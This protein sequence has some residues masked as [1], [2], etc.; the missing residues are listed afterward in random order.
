[1]SREL[2][3]VC[4]RMPPWNG[5][6][7]QRVRV[8][9]PQLAAHGW[10]ATVL[11]LDES[12]DAGSMDP[13]LLATVP[14]EAELQRVRAWPLRTAG[15]LG[16]RQTAL[17]GWWPLRRA[18]R[19][20]LRRRRFDAAL[21]S[22]TDFA[23]WP[24]SLSLPCPVL[25]DWQDPWLSD[26]Y[27]RHP[28]VPRPG[29]RLRYGLMQAIAR[30]WEPRVARRAAGHLVVSP[31]YRELLC[32]RYPDLRPERF[33]VLPFAAA[34][35][36]LALARRRGGRPQLLAGRARWWV[37]AGRGGEDLHFAWRA[38]FE[39]LAAER[40]ADPARYEG[41]G[42]LFVGTAY[43]VRQRTTPLAA[44][45]A[46]CGV[47]D[48]VVEHPQRVGLLE[49]YRLMDAADA[50]VVPGSDDPGY[51]ASK[52]APCLLTGRPL[53]AALHAA[54]SAHRLAA[55]H[56]ATDFIPF[57]PSAPGAAATLRETMR[58][59]WLQRP[60]PAPAER[61]ELGDLEAAGMAARICAHLDRIV[62]A[63]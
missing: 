43:D 38:L 25:L 52:L 39:A 27:D 60:L 17:R 32:A 45:A 26:Y 41:F 31:A 4:P 44:L 50:V 54:S 10:R 51:V 49:T 18:Q 62:A 42:L 24:L 14:A 6:D 61:V 16:L 8:L 30:R 1:M 47:G 9:L 12:S 48:L 34:A 36:D 23:L 59:R 40:A 20:L 63:A 5:A 46:D 53:L 11:A 7:A 29:G 13:E 15:R 37:S 58:R 19:R 57:D 22:H 21:V 55:A 33:E 56:G 35:T 3:V 2:L 28:D